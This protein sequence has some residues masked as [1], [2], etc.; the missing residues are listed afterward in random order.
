M[1]GQYL[2]LNCLY[3]ICINYRKIFRVSMFSKN[4]Q[5]KLPK[6]KLCVSKKSIN[7]GF[8]WLGKVRMKTAIFDLIREIQ[9]M[10]GKFVNLSGIF[11]VGEILSL[12]CI[13]VSINPNIIVLCNH[14]FANHEN[15]VLWLYYQHG[16]Q[17]L[18]SLNSLNCS[19]FFFAT[20]NILEKVTFSD[21]FLNCSEF[22]FFDKI[23]SP[24]NQ[25]NLKR[26]RKNYLYSFNQG[27]VGNNLNN[28]LS[29]N[30]Y[31]QQKF[32]SFVFII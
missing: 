18:N 14:H 30:N 29:N 12:F 6:F 2:L 16:Y 22:W 4:R 26:L 3:I 28:N 21:W 15:I 23:L 9:G 17:F 25:E 27:K 7:T 13:L 24:L 11:F 8:V 32:V 20:W 5:R 31:E 19:E 1:S 10:S